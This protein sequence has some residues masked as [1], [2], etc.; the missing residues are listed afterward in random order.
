MRTR[1]SISKGQLTML[2]GSSEFQLKSAILTESLPFT[3][4][5][6]TAGTENELQAVVSGKRTTVDLP[7]LD[8]AFKVLRK[9]CPASGNRRSLK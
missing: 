9:H 1:T 5:D 4:G 7:H 3:P 6:I 2:T 8:R